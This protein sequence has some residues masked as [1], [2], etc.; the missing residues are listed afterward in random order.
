M[1]G[2]LNEILVKTRQV[3]EAMQAIEVAA[4]EQDTGLTQ[5]NT[6]MAQMDRL[7]QGNAAAAEEAARKAVP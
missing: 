6:A 5:I 7:T 3:D 2:R 4:Q 1:H